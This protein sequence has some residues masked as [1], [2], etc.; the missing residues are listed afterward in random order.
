M[1]DKEKLDEC[2]WALQSIVRGRD[3]FADIE[4][5]AQ[6]AEDKLGYIGE[7][8]WGNEPGD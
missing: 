5:T 6:Y 7:V 1:T 8:P 3:N 4:D 2:I